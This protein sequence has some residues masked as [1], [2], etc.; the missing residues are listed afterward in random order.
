MTTHLEGKAP[1]NYH[2]ENI[3]GKAAIVTGGTTGSGRATARLLAE[4]GARVLIFGRDE[5]DLQEALNEL[6]QCGEVHGVQAD[7]SRLED[8]QRIFA[9][10]D[11][12]LGGVDI[13]VNNAAVSAGGIQES[14]LEEIRYGLEANVLGYMACTKEAVTRMKAK[15]AGHIVCVGSL[16]AD[17]REEENDVYVATK[18]AIQAF[19]ESLRKGINPLGIKV[20]LI[21]PGRVGTDM[22]SESPEEQA[23]K[24]Q[25]GEM[26][27]AEDIA[28]AVHY[29]L[30]QPARC[31][32]I[33]VQ[34]RPHLQSI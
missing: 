25:R 18:A 23:Q 12:Q 9:E 19:S 14:E 24:Q 11:T 32:V 17:Q 1:R 26:L 22:P 30:T 16:S 10:A 2:P 8:V 28:E 27:K 21:E 33:V 29:C 13:L 4:R 31:D 6:K 20:S 3:E 15:G 7:Q 5:N 34:I